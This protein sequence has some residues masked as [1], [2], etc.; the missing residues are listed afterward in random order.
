MSFFASGSNDVESNK[1][2]KT[3]GCSFKYLFTTLAINVKIL[4]FSKN[5]IKISN[6]SNF[7]TFYF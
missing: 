1:S 4:K 3:S 6:R 2:I 5:L 7:I